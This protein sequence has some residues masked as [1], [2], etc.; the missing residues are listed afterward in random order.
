MPE[1]SRFFGIV[2]QM[3]YRDHHPPHFH[4]RYGDQKAII[5]IDGL[6]TLGGQMTP[7]VYGMVIE[8][9]VLHQDELRENWELARRQEPLNKIAPL[10]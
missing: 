9:A 5:S 2:I 4:V 6:S 7:R 1:I 3:Y 10:E 8:W